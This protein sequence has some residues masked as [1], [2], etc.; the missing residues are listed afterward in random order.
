MVTYS[1][2]AAFLLEIS[3]FQLLSFGQILE[4]NY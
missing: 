3:L 1:C 4:K 2:I